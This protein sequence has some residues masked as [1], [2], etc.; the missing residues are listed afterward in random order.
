[1]ISKNKIKLIRS[2]ELKKFR[3][4]E[5]LFLAEGNKLT[6]EVLK[7]GFNVKTLICTE[8]FYNHV[9]KI[10]A[11]PDEIIIATQEEIR[12]CSLL[13]NPQQALVLC[14]IPERV[15][16]FDFLRNKLALALDGIRDPGNLGTVVRVADWFGIKTVCASETT[17][18]LF[19]P[20]VVQATM[21][22]ILRVN[23][24]YTDL[25][26]V[27][28]RANSE[29][30]PTFGAFLS[31]NNIYSENLPETGIIVM[32]NEGQGIVPELEQQIACKI[33]IPPLSRGTGEVSESLNVSMATSIICS[34]FRRRQLV[35]YSK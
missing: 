27:I 15:F 11:T 18:D 8:T 34:E 9:G 5:N 1:M 25:A 4:K 31:G 19:N 23:V 32:G 20:K 14:Q 3:V 16:E 26:E 29:N 24:Y 28:K 10:S 13:K 21:G 2:L 33:Y 30:I 7:S 35:G 6:Q 17:A 22:A 12:K